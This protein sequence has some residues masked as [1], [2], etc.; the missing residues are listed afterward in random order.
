M[1]RASGSPRHKRANQV[2]VAVHDGRGMRTGLPTG[3]IQ[4]AISRATNATSAA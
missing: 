1:R 2:R 3:A 4:A